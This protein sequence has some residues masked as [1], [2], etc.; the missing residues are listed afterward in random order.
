MLKNDVLSRNP[1]ESEKKIAC[2]VLLSGC[3]LKVNGVYSGP[4]P[5]SSF[6]CRGNLF[7]SFCEILCKPSGG[8][9][10]VTKLPYCL[11][12]GNS[13]FQCLKSPHV[14]LLMCDLISLWLPTNMHCHFRAKLWLGKQKSVLS[15][16]Q[17]VLTWSNLHGIAHNH[18]NKRDELIAT[19]PWA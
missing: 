12:H 2:P 19:W 1:K 13:V 8:F 4:R 7:R 15:S 11:E 16:P 6:K 3:A 18:T 17:T 5:I 14:L 9:L 10:F